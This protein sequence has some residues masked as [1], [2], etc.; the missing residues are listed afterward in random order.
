MDDLVRRL[1]GPGGAPRLAAGS[2]CTERGGD[3]VMT[4]RPIIFSAPM[5]RALLDGQEVADAA[6]QVMTMQPPKDRLERLRE[7]VEQANEGK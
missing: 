3:V 7:A 2:G 1:R 5:I 6:D 4:D